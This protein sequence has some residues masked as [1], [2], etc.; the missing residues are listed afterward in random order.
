MT[1]FIFRCLRQYRPYNTRTNNIPLFSGKHN[2]FRKSFFPPT[3]IE[4]DNLDL[5]IRN[6]ETISAFKKSIL[7]FI[8]TYSN[9][10]FNCC[11]PNGIKLITRLRLGYSHLREHKFS[12]NFQ[13]TLN[14]VCSRKDDIETTIHFKEDTF[15]QSS[16]YWRK[17]S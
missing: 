2:L 17:H 12:Q 14:P 7:K 9:S 15:G 13:H 1:L 8:R 6:S 11:S 4:W 10:V 3:V 16:K 5:K